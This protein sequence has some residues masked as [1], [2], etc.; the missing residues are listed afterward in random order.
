MCLAECAE[1]CP[2]C[3]QKGCKEHPGNTAERN[4][5]EFCYSKTGGCGSSRLTL[6]EMNLPRHE[7]DQTGDVG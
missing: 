6:R 7:Q 3:L 2:A 4:L 5:L 1:T